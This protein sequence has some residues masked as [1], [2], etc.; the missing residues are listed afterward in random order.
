MDIF[1]DNINEAMGDKIIKD[2]QMEM[3]LESFHNN[4]LLPLIFSLNVN[5]DLT[6]ILDINQ[7]PDKYLSNQEYKELF[8]KILDKIN[9]MNID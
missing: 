7:T 8:E 3:K 2:K 9:I 4:L 5:C 1:L 6:N